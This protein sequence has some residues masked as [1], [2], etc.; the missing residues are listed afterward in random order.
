MIDL[1][2]HIGAQVHCTDGHCGKLV[3]VVVDPTTQRVTDLIVEKGFLLKHDR[4]LP[5]SVVDRATEKDIYLNIRSDELERYGEYREYYIKEPSPD[6]GGFSSR[7]EFEAG[8]QRVVP[9]IRRRVREGIATGKAVIERATEVDNLEK[10]IGHVDHI[11]ADRESRQITHFVMRRGLIPEYIVVPMELVER[12]DEDAIFT[13][14]TGEDLRELP[15][16]KPANEEEVLSELR[17]RLATSSEF[18]A[19]TATMTAGIVRLNGQV[20]HEAA[21][22]HAEELAREIEGVIEVDN[23]LYVGSEEET[24]PTNGTINVVAQV[25]AA[26]AADPRTRDAVIEVIGDRRAVILKGQVN[27]PKTRE[28]AG[29]I[30]ASQ[31]GVTSVDNEL[32]VMRN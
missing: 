19:V 9:M 10:T 11:M 4:V 18:R 8:V 27:S 15:R 24:T 17:Q 1:N 14:V 29:E 5:V 32:V 16:Y 20:R 12:V 28:I 13:T 3:K 22:Q 26:L 31:P 6:A 7:A 23:A 2:L 25:S 30:T 21:R